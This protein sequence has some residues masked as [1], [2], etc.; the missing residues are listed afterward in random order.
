M[1]QLNTFKSVTHQV[2]SSEA[3]VYTAPAGKTGIILLAQITN[4]STT[5]AESVT[6][7]L[8]RSGSPDTFIVS[9]YEVPPSDA[10]SILTGK[11]VLQSG[12]SITVQGGTS[13]DLILSV[14]EATDG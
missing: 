1:A 3:T 9:G 4:P 2:T 8:V 7:R 5:A 11:L 13:L 6:A 14:L 12:D 10:S